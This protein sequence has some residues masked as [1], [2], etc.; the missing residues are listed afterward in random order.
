L[1]ALVSLFRYLY[2]CLILPE[3]RTSGGLS[4]VLD[5]R[6]GT[7]SAI[8]RIFI[9]NF[10]TSLTK[11]FSKFCVAVSGFRMVGDPIVD[12]IYETTFSTPTLHIIGK[13]D[14]VVIEERSHQLAKISTNARVEEHDGGW[15]QIFF[16]PV[17]FSSGATT[18]GISFPPRQIGESS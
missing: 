11:K 14:V 1:T 13:N 10:D 12:A 6:T 17:C 3:A 8:A 2:R 7:A 9:S 18:Q 15:C 4:S 16:D 5:R